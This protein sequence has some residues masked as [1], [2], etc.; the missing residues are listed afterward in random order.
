MFTSVQGLRL[1]LSHRISQQAGSR[2]PE[3]TLYTS[4][5]PL[6]ISSQK[7]CPSPLDNLYRVHQW[8]K[9]GSAFHRCCKGKARGQNRTREVGGNRSVSD[10]SAERDCHLFT[11][12]SE[13]RTWEATSAIM[14]VTPHYPQY[15]LFPKTSPSS[16]TVTSSKVFDPEPS[17]LKSN[18]HTNSSCCFTKHKGKFYCFSHKNEKDNL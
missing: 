10:V 16:R 7:H 15:F 5:L 17:H 4:M 9:T 1:R 13:M 8:N 2:K 14:D 12:Q 11:S 3:V 18:Q 6:P